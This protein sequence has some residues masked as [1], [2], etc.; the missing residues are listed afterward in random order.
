VNLFLYW[1]RNPP[2]SGADVVL[3]VLYSL[4][5]VGVSLGSA[6]LLSKHRKELG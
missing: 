1:S 4:I 5:A 6:V 3:A 2:P